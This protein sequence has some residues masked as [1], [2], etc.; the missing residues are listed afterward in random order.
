MLLTVI[1]LLTAVNLFTVFFLFLHYFFCSWVF[2]LLTS[3]IP[4]YAYPF[5]LTKVMLD[6]CIIDE[7]SLLSEESMIEQQVIP[8]EVPKGTTQ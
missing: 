1:C 2:F 3:F 6:H 8:K 4:I 5:C 7:K